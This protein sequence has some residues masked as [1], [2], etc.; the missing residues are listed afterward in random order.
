MRSHKHP[1]ALCQAIVARGGAAL[2]AAHKL[3][4][5]VPHS[6][7][8]CAGQACRSVQSKLHRIGFVSDTAQEGN[9]AVYLSSQRSC[10]ASIIGNV[11]WMLAAT[12]PGAR[13]STLLKVVSQQVGVL[14]VPVVGHSMK[15]VAKAPTGFRTPCNTACCF[16]S[17]ILRPMSARSFAARFSI[18]PNA[19]GCPSE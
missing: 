13:R 18:N 12:R 14:R 5:H 15:G 11:Y 7:R 16:A 2:R 4:G 10:A 1:Y 9:S 6:S 19:Q 8:C 3:M 17:V